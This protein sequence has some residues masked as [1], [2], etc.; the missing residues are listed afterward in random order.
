[1]PILRQ[2][3]DDV[4]DRLVAK[5]HVEHL[6]GLIEH[7]RFKLGQVAK[8]LVDQIQQAP[9]RC[10]DDVDA[11]FERIDLMELTD[12]AEDRCHARLQMATERLEAPAAI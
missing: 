11:F 3:C 1:M 12:A 6:V 7:Q 5:A 9:R 2:R 8:A 4:L 10:H